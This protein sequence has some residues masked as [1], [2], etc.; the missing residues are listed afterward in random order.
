MVLEPWSQI[1]TH[2][3]TLYYMK[4]K[5]LVRPKNEN[6]VINYSRLCHSKSHSKYPLLS[7]RE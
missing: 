3:L 1:L 7:F 4:P 2:L 6:T 5:G